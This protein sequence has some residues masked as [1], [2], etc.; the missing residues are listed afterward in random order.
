MSFINNPQSQLLMTWTG[1]QQR[2]IAINNS[3]KNICKVN[4]LNSFVFTHKHVYLL[5]RQLRTG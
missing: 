2:D 5:K 4:F 3:Y 1:V